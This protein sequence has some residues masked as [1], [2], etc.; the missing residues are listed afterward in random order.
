MISILDPE[1]DNCII[2]AIENGKTTAEIE[3][4]LER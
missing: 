4:I 1:D 2:S 3:N